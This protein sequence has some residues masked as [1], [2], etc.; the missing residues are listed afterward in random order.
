LKYYSQCASLKALDLNVL[1]DQS[2]A[3]V[4]VRLQSYVLA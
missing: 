4:A 2:L 1:N 3:R